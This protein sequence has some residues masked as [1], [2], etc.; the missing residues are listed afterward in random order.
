MDVSINAVI[1]FTDVLTQKRSWLYLLFH[2]I[3]SIVMTA[4]L[5]TL[6][7]RRLRKSNA[8]GTTCGMI[9][10]RNSDGRLL[11]T[12]DKTMSRCACPRGPQRWILRIINILI[13]TGII[14]I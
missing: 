12:T 10:I 8:C 5:P 4:W 7:K 9:L 1:L 6:S 3:L 11:Y 2:A 13:F 14:S